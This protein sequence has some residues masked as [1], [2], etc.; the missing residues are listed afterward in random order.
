MQVVVCGQLQR[1]W[2]GQQLQEGAM[3]MIAATIGCAYP[4]CVPS[5]S[6]VL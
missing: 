6:C 1:L 4:G 2:G 3:R 5:R